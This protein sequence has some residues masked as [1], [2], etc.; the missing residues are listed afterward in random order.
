METNY[1]GMT[2]NERLFVGGLLNEFDQAVEKREIDRV[3]EILKA[4]EMPDSAI[5]PILESVGLK[6]SS[7]L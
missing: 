2:V 4:V 5:A 1:S 7:E 6:S 3:I